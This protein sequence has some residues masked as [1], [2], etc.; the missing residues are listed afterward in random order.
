MINKIRI[1]G[2]IAVVTASAEFHPLRQLSQ[3]ANELKAVGFKGHVLFDL[4]SVNG[5]SSNRFVSVEFNGNAFDR[6]SLSVESSIDPS[7]QE[8]QNTL[9]KKN[10]NFL[11][12]SVLSQFE[13]NEFLH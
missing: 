12:D 2:K 7:L 4:L 9:I 8:E 11:K 6:S 13:I 5:L 1:I 3:L 10:P